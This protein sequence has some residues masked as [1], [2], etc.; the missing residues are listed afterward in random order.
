M[1]STPPPTTFW[2]VLRQA[3]RSFSM[4]KVKGSETRIGRPTW[5][6]ASPRRRVRAGRHAAAAGFAVTGV[7]LAPW[8][9]AEA[10]GDAGHLRVGAEAQAGVEVNVLARQGLGGE[11]AAVEPVGAAQVVA[12]AHVAGGRGGEAPVALVPA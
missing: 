1:K 3:P 8:R 5:S 2:G 9:D 4:V 11:V 12:A 10:P 7:A 6:K